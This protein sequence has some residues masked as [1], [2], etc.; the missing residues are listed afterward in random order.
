MVKKAQPDAEMLKGTMDM[1]ILR[2][3][4]GGDAHG[5]TIAKI[6]ER[7]SEDVLEVVPQASNNVPPI[8]VARAALPVCARK[9]RRVIEISMVP[10]LRA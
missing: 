9:R 6:I 4:V 7:T 1:M 8:P 10:L 5:H 2:T 3:L